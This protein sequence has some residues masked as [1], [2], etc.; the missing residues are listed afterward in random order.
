[1]AALH[2]GNE[3]QASK[4]KSSPELE[5][6]KAALRRS[7]KQ[8]LAGRL[9]ASVMHE[10]NNPAEA[11]G[12]LVY[13]IAQNADNPEFVISLSRQVEEQLLRIRYASR[14]TLSFFKEYP[15]RQ[16]TDL[17]ALIDTVIRFYTPSLAERKIRLQMQVP[18][19]LIVAVFPG[20]FLQLVSNLV[21]NAIDA[22]PI[23]GVLCIRL[24]RL[25]QKVRLTVADNG[26]GIPRHLR[27]HLFEPFETGKADTG[28]GL[29]LWICKTV[30][31]R[32][33]GHLSWRTNTEPETHGTTFSL[34]IAS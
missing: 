6:L 1:V 2:S 23:G 12:N 31:E 25:R 15:L 18:D 32:H 13:L 29:G 19:K 16:D 7:E 10:I 27:S 22:I 28:H 26:S 33:G 5:L 20:D 21:G 9:T 3:S 34:S 17:V 4:E 11:I 30:A 14:Q 8:A 24:R